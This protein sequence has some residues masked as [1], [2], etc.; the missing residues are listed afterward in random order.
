MKLNS[1]ERAL[2]NNPVRAAHQHY[3]EA[4]WFKRLVGGT[5][6]GQHVL[7]LANPHRGTYRTVVQIA[8]GATLEHEAELQPVE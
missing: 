5:L 1:I 6:S 3:R 8:P 2:V 4:E 7:E